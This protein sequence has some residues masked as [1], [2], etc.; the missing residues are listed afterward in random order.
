M[1]ERVYIRRRH[2]GKKE[3]FEEYRGS[4]ERIQRENE[5]RSKEARKN[6]HGRGERL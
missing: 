1:I 5:C 2:L 4:F 6:R 3:K